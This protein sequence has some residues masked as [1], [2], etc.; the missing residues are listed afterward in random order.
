MSVDRQ[1]INSR[2]RSRRSIMKNRKFVVANGDKIWRSWRLAN[3]LLQLVNSLLIVC[4][5]FII[6]FVR[7]LSNKPLHFY[8][9]FHVT[10]KEGHFFNNSYSHL[11]AT[12]IAQICT[13]ALYEKV[14]YCNV[15]RAS[16]MFIKFMWL[17]KYYNVH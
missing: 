12:P 2:W 4:I 17:V 8:C 7:V 1:F 11:E 16:G 10:F 13:L 6:I 5:R 9:N 3:K 15:W 14:A